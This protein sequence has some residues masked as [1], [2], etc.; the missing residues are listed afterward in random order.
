[1]KNDVIS[2]FKANL[3]TDSI[4]KFQPLFPKYLNETFV[5]PDFISNNQ[6]LIPHFFSLKKY[7]ETSRKKYN[8]QGI[9][10]CISIV[11]FWYKLKLNLF[12]W[13]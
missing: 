11:Y 1:M 2:F 6:K 13:F 12:Q 7:L 3:K 10:L 4:G 9:S 5:Y 8:F